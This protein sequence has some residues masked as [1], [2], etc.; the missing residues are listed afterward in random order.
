MI[1]GD[2]VSKVEADIKDRK[3]HK[4]VKLNIVVKGVKEAEDNRIGFDYLYD[5]SYGDDI[6]YIKVEGTMFAQEEEGM[7]DKILRDWKDKKKIADNYMERLLNAIN[8]S[9]TAHSTIIARVLSYSP[10][11]VPPKITVNKKK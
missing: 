4:G 5:V 8:F 11:L 7:R 1:I 10:P 6:G 2:K 3:Q 9:A